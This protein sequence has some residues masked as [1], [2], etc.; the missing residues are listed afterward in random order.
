MIK[1]LITD[2]HAMFRAGLKHII[3]EEFDMLVAGEAANG[4]E[5]MSKILDKDY[6]VVVLDINMPGRDG[7]EVLSEIKAVKPNIAVLVLSMYSE[8]QFAIRALREGASGYLTKESAPDELTSAIREVFRGGKYISPTVAQILAYNVDSHSEKLLHEKLSDREY[9]VMLQITI[10]KKIREIAGEL[11]LS[12]KTI[13]TYR[14]RILEK[15]GMETNTEL[16]QYA[17]RHK[18]LK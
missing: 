11:N 9:E 15:M 2:D 13:S 3:D 14:T 17:I 7:I 1:V 16:T 10:G 12:G 5:V 18:L 4:Q 6:D 8:E